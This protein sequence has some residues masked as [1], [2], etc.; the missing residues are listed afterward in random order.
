MITL[1]LWFKPG[2][3]INQIEAVKEIVM[4]MNW[5]MDDVPQADNSY[6]VNL[7]IEEAPMFFIIQDGI[8]AMGEEEAK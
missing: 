6:A 1:H 5:Q 3:T 2:W 4:R 7:P 8:D